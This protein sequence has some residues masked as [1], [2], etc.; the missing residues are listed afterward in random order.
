MTKFSYE[1]ERERHDEE[2]RQRT[3]IESYEQKLERWRGDWRQEIDDD[4]NHGR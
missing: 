2:S 1:I 3:G 4:L